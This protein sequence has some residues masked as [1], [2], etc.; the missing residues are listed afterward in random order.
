MREFKTAAEMREHYKTVHA[1]L[2][3]LTPPQVPA[4]LMPEPPPDPKI[5]PAEPPELTVAEITRVLI[6]DPLPGSMR[7]I[8][9]LVA[10]FFGADLASIYGPWRHQPVTEHRHIAMFFISEFCSNKGTPSIGRLFHRDP[11]TVVHALSSIAQSKAD[12]PYFAAKLDECR[13]FIKERWP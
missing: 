5:E 3:G 2:K 9:A 8:V 13:Q 10:E 11:A 7:K 1:R 12:D 4:P 6:D